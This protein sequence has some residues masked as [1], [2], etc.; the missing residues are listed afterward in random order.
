MK[1][2]LY[3]FFITGLISACRKEEATVNRTLPITGA[4][5]VASTTGTFYTD[6]TVTDK[7]VQA[8]S[9]NESYYFSEDGTFRLSQGDDTFSVQGRWQ[10]TPAGN[11]LTLLTTGGETLQWTISEVTDKRLVLSHVQQIPFNGHTQRL[12][13]TTTCLR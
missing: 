3:I 9:A 5:Q 1:L 2:I 4:W 13:V 8:G 12:E 10:Y 11:R 6:G 7:Q